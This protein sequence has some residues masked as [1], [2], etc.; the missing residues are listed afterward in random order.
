[1]KTYILSSRKFFTHPSNGVIVELEDIISRLCDATVVCPCHNDSALGKKVRQILR[2]DLP[3]LP[4]KAS[5]EGIRQERVLLYFSMTAEFL[6]LLDTLPNWRKEFAVV[7]AYVVDPWWPRARVP[8]SI[9]RKLDCLFV[10]DER[11]ANRYRHKYLART[12]AVPLATDVLG[13]GSASLI[14]PLD[15]V[16]YG[17]QAPSYLRPIVSRYNSPSSSRFIYHDTLKERYPCSLE[18]D[19]IGNRRLIWNLLRKSRV[20]LAFRTGLG[21]THQEEFIPIRYYEAAAAGAAIVG[22]HP[23][24]AEM[25]EQFTWPDALIELPDEPADTVDFLDALLDDIPRLEAI[26]RR[27]HREALARHDWRYRIRDIFASLGLQ[28]PNALDRE[29]DILK[30]LTIV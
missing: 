14:R 15:V 13:M 18:T 11:I 28:L 25:Q 5:L 6:S 17:R 9:L 21:G 10:P 22:K 12:Q 16:A 2:R 23:D 7:A 27:N 26:H 1:M 3:P 19:F 4:L 30:S 24:T 8:Q 29:L 20:S